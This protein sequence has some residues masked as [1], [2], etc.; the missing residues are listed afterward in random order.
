MKI[1]HF[2][3]SESNTLTYLLVDQE[4]LDA[5]IIDP[6]LDYDS[7]TGE[8]SDSNINKVIDYIRTQNLRVKAILETHAHADHL[9]SSQILKNT[10]PEAI[11]AISKDITEV[12]NV[13]RDLFNCHYVLADGSQFDLLLVDNQVYHFGSLSMKAF[14]T[15]GHTPACMSYLFEDHLFV[16]DALFMPDSG[17][18]RCDFPK[19]S[20]YKLYQSITE[21][22]YTLPDETYIYVGHDYSPAGREL[23]FQTTVKESKETNIQL[24]AQTSR[25]EYVTFREARDKTLKAPKLLIPSIQININAGKLPPKEDNATRYIKIPL[26][27]KTRG[28]L[29]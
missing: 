8:I 3:D 22:I 20:A 14:S 4:T 9:S 27:I 18:G 23:K 12:Q 28:A 29:I 21:K 25:E 5:V 24:K 1:E 6:V 26:T 10:Y 17:T 11:L 15:P 2:L 16:G 7:T 19:G 13:F